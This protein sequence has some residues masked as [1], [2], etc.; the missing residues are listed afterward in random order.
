MCL[1]IFFIVEKLKTT[2]GIKKTSIFFVFKF[3]VFPQLQQ[4]KNI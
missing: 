4:A 1:F 3:I 2:L